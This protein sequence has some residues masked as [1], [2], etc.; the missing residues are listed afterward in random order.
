MANYNKESRRIHQLLSR[1]DDVDEIRE[2]MKGNNL[3]DITF[4]IGHSNDASLNYL[5]PYH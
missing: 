4:K 5:N 3:R 1:F 2:A